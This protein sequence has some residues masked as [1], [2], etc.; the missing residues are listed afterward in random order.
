MFYVL[1]KLPL[2]TIVIFTLRSIPFVFLRALTGLR[3]CET[4]M[5]TFNTATP[6]VITLTLYKKHKV[7]KTPISQHLIFQIDEIKIVQ[8][9]QF[10]FL[11][12]I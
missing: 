4:R 12:Y 8:D 10:V 2:N 5:M 11:Q 7:G 9:F 3:K 1:K 6:F